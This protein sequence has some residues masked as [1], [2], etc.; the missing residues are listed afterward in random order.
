MISWRGMTGCVDESLV[1]F[2]ELRGRHP[3]RRRLAVPQTV[4]DVTEWDRFLG[5]AKRGLE[6]KSQCLSPLRTGGRLLRRGCCPAL[7]VGLQGAQILQIAL[8][9]SPESPRLE[10]S[11]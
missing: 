10:E 3:P 5:V 11:R 9:G 4:P 6:I 2:C 7:S 8:Y 1:L